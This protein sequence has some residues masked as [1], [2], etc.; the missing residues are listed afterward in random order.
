MANV[1]GKCPHCGSAVTVDDGA[2]AAVCPACGEAFVVAKAIAAAEVSATSPCSIVR[3]DEFDVRGGVLTRCLYLTE[4]PV[5]PAG[6]T[7]I[8]P[9][10]FAGTAIV[11]VGIPEGVTLIGSGAF[12][13]CAALCAVR[14]PDT[15][16][17]I[18][19]SAFCGCAAL[20]SIEMPAVRV[21]HQGAFTNCISLKKLDLPESLRR[22]G[23]CSAEL[24]PTERAATGE[25]I[26]FGCSALTEVM[27]HGDPDG[28]DGLFVSRFT[29]SFARRGIFAFA[30]ASPGLT[31]FF[32][33]DPARRPVL[34]CRR[35]GCYIATAVYGSYDCPEVWTLRRFRDGTLAQSAAGRAFIRCYYALSPWLV[36]RFG[37]SRAVRA[38]WRLPLDFLVKHLR[39][40]GVSGTPY[41]DD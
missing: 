29:G 25:S 27:V 32:L 18:G 41:E 7:A 12:R 6:V 8:G 19:E 5:I 33:A 40:R 30:G 39:R 3:E 35:K 17:E 11:S 38:A 9:D 22:L 16:A 14:L 10:A 15:L 1:T 26:A 21:I 24:A 2:A 13:G 20:E 4:E 34:P 37:G 31:V 23:V 36:R 28:I